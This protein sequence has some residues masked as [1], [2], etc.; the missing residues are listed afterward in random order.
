MAD[1][2]KDVVPVLPEHIHMIE[3]GEKVN[4]Y[5]IVE[6]ASL[7]LVYTT[8]VGLEMA[9]SGKP[10]IVTGDT[11]YRGRGFT[12]D[13]DSWVSYYKT[14]GKILQKPKDQWLTDEQVELAW[15]YAYTFFYEYPLPFPWHLVGLWDDVKI[16]PMSEVFSK[17]HYERYA[18]TFSYLTGKPIDWKS[19]VFSDKGNQ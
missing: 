19:I 11:H 4:T 13:P 5:D 1:I 6:I 18:P 2:V 8:T 3:P 17:H 12:F 15:R 16:R 14:L 7:G 9:M 10:V